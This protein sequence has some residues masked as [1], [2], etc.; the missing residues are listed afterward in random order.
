MVK[1]LTNHNC[2]DFAGKNHR[3]DITGLLFVE[4]GFAI[5]YIE[6]PKRKMK[7]LIKNIQN[8]DRQTQFE[9]IS[10][11]TSFTRKFQQWDMKYIIR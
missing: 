10:E 8:D 3:N 11:G 2:R 9:V 5:Q 4:D 7:Q 6:G 1:K